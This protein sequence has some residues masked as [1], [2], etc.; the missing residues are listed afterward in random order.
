[1]RLPSPICWST[2]LLTL[3]ALP[4]TATDAAREAMQ[5][6]LNERTMAIPFNPGDAARA[7]AW[8]EQ[9]R[10]VNVVPVSKPPTYWSPGWTCGH[11]T[12][13]PAYN[14]ND[15]RSCI[16]YRQYHGHYWR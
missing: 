7:Q 10:R 2:A 6:S 16:Y 14:F 15:Y 8:A 1:M 5:R 13:Y 11:L 12:T 3:T 4:A 9:A